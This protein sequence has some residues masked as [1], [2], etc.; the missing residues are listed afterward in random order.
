MYPSLLAKDPI[1]ARGG[2]LV[3]LLRLITV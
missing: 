1:M 2:R 3:S